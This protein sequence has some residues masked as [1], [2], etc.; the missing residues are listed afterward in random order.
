YV[1]GPAELLYWLQLKSTFDHFSIPF[2]VL[3]PRNFALV[4]DGQ[5]ARKLSKTG[6]TVENFFEAKNYLFN[7]WV[8]KYSD[9]NLSLGESLKLLEAQLADIQKRCENIDPTLIRMVSAEGK[10]LQH[11][12]E[13]IERKMIRA[14]KR[15]HA[16][17][18]RQIEFVKDA[19][20]PNGGLQERTDNFLNFYQ[21]DPSFI[22]K[23]TEA[24]D[25]FDF[26]MNVLIEND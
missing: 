15:R 11:A 19:L 13:T 14:E 25:S 10:R 12:M 18:L 1:G 6:L 2:P 23:I 26:Q 4:I 17:K 5:V 8:S 21:K 9:H 20:F 7:H 16:D 3:L 24:F 22:R